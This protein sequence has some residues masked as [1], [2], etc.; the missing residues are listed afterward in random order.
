[1]RMKRSGKTPILARLPDRS[2]QAGAHVVSVTSPTDVSLLFGRQLMRAVATMTTARVRDLC[3]PLPLLL[4][5]QYPSLLAGLVPIEYR[6][7]YHCQQNNSITVTWLLAP[8][9]TAHVRVCVCVCAHL[10]KL[11]AAPSPPGGACSQFVPRGQSHYTVTSGPTGQSYLATR[12]RN[13]KIEAWLLSLSP[14]LPLLV[15]TL[16]LFA[17]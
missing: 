1:M 9:T 7:T 4:F 2:T 5:I 15:K 16:D 12:G 6:S 14:S 3:A 10:S 8:I 11:R 13:R 17:K